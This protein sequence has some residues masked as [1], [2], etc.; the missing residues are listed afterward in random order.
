VRQLNQTPTVVSHD[1]TIL[2]L[3]ERK[4]AQPHK[5]G[6]T[7]SIV[8]TLLATKPLWSKRTTVLLGDTY[9]DRCLPSIQSCTDNIRFF[10]NADEIFALSFTPHRTLD[11]AI[12]KALTS[13]KA[14]LWQLYR[15]YE[16]IPLTQ[17]IILTNRIF[18]VVS[19]LT[20][21]IDTWKEYQTL[22]RKVNG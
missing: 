20:D 12:N 5:L 14:K 22:R 8:K 16:G 13:K 1:P 11:H 10:G 4:Q 2:S 15:A 17:H 18:T 7:T 21:D 9:Y 3:S 19:D 6:P